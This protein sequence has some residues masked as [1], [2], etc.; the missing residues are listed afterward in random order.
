LPIAPDAGKIFLDAAVGPEER[1]VDQLNVDDGLGRV[2]DLDQLA[3][4]AS[5]SAVLSALPVC[6]AV[7]PHPV[8][9]SYYYLMNLSVPTDK[10]V[11]A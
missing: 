8:R 2:R 6:G 10:S 7:N 5:T 4:A 11:N 9:P 1:Q 3:R